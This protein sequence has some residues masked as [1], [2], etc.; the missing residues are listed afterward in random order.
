M[1]LPSPGCGPAGSW[2][3]LRLEKPD[4][5][6]ISAPLPYAAC[7]AIKAIQVRR[8]TRLEPMVC[9][10]LAILTGTQRRQLACSAEFR[11]AKRASIPECDCPLAV[12]ESWC[13]AAE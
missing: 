3:L 10:C 13:R 12:P 1:A 9:S 2:T 4:L 5:K 6:P 11:I 8:G 7:H